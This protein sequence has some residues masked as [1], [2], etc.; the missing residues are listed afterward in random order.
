MVMDFLLRSPLGENVQRTGARLCP[1]TGCDNQKEYRYMSRKVV[2]G[3]IILMV[4]ACE[5]DS[6]SDEYSIIWEAVRTKQSCT[7]CCHRG[8]KCDGGCNTAYTQ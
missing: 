3:A 2:P 8:D 6:Y 1:D 4:R 5:N 7:R